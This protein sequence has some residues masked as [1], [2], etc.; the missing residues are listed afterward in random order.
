MPKTLRRR[1][2][3]VTKRAGIATEVTTF[4]KQHYNNAYTGEVTTGIA[5]DEDFW[6]DIQDEYDSNENEA[7]RA[8]EVLDRRWKELS[9]TD[10]FLTVAQARWQLLLEATIRGFTID[11][12]TGVVGRRGDK[13]ELDC[14]ISF[15]MAMA[16]KK[17]I[18]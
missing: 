6:D 13:D 15:M 14:T 7:R 12:K 8:S 5:T 11:L 2:S 4:I 9:G 16:T 3:A 10:D 18:K 1:T 17:G